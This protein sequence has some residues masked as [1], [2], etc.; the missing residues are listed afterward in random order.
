MFLSKLYLQSFVRGKGFGRKAIE[1]IEEIA[2]KESC[3]NIWLSVYKKNVDSIKAYEKCGFQITGP[4]YLDIGN[5]YVMDDHKME[6][7]LQL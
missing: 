7:L 6:K 2:K 5:G 3:A 4:Y 1:F